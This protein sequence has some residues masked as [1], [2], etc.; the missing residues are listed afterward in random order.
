M[1][2]LELTLPTPQE[3]LALDDRVHDLATAHCRRQ[4]VVARRQLIA[5]AL[6][7]GQQAKGQPR[8]DQPVVLQCLADGRGGRAR[9][10]GRA[11]PRAPFGKAETSCP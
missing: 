6:A 10:S 5:H 9:P 2:L 11:F 4:V 7:F 1:H 3:H 8:T